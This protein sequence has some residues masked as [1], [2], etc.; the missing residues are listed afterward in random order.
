MSIR[1]T[2]PDMAEVLRQL[3]DPK[4]AK[5]AAKSAINDGL[6]AGKAAAGQEVAADYNTGPRSAFKGS[7]TVKAT[8]SRLKGHVN[9]NNPPQTLKKWGTDPKSRRKRKNPEVTGLVKRAGNAVYSGVFL[10]KSSGKTQ[11]WIRVSNKRTDI[12][13]VYGPS[14]S[15]LVRADR[16]Q[17][18][19]TKRANEQLQ[20]RLKHH[21]NYLMGQA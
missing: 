8:N 4:K 11:A 5:L 20:K 12:R 7:R 13:P 9:F 1:I 19:Y 6:A 18:R 3:P 21:I 17:E 15:Q 2:G 10:G 14:P 16:V